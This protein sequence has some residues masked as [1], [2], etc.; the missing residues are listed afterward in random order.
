MAERV[1]GFEIVSKY[2][3]KGINLP[4]RKTKYSAG[5]DIEAGETVTIPSIWKQVFGFI[6]DIEDSTGKEVDSFEEITSYVTAMI[7]SNSVEE[8]M[9]EFNL[10]PTLIPTGLRAYMQDDEVLKLFNRSSTPLKKGLILAND[11][12]II[13]KDFYD[14][15]IESG[16]GHFYAQYLNFLP[17]DVTINKGEA[18]CQGIF[19]KYLVT[20]TDDVSAERNGGM[21]STDKQG[22]GS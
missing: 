22:N 11:V 2:E 20:D 5:H 9:K 13:D 21:G 4:I 14:S 12:A 15:P 16:E 18:V 7:L 10:R 8:I 17:F 19:E 1:R 3:E 6:T